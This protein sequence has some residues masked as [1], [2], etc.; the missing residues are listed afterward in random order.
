ME[1][2]IKKWY[3]NLKEGKIMGLRCKECG[4][5]HFPPVPVCKECSGFDM[6]WVEMSGEAE[7][8]TINSNFQGVYPYNNTPSLSGFVKLKE[9]MFF[10]VVLDG[11]KPSE[12]GALVKRLQGGPVKVQLFTKALNEKYAY[13]FGRLVD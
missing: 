2:I 3:D 6:E 4:S 11:V 5:I 9:G 12:Q 10:I 7:L 1:A 8:Y 13:P